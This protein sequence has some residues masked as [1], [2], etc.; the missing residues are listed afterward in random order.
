MAV[1]AVCVGDWTA[2]EALA[3]QIGVRVHFDDD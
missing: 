2:R 1:E 3:R